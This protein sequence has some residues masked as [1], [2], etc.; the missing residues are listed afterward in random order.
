MIDVGI[1]T[2]CLSI[3]ALRRIAD[4]VEPVLRCTNIE[5]PNTLPD[6]VPLSVGDNK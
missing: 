3:Y 5:D 6:F 1:Q 2:P 4:S